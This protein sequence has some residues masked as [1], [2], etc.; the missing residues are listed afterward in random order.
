MANFN[1]ADYETVDQRIR[2]FYADHPTG[3]ITT[4]L[5]SADGAPGSTRWVVKA[6][7]WRG[8]RGGVVVDNEKPIS[9][10]VHSLDLAP[11]GTGYAF[12][13]D[14]TG[15]ANKTSALE[16]C[17]TSAIG[18]ALANIGYSGD[19]RASREEMAKAAAGPVVDEAA[20]AEWVTAMEGAVDLNDLQSAW[21]AAGAKGV[22]RDPRV[23]TAK[24][25]RK[26]ELADG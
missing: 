3:R 10:M 8:D 5:V 25:K 16:N 11:D 18:R 17:E 15:M 12:E 24:D 6:S 9:E 1:L 21:N 2:R 26:K 7:V 4:E 22:T 23:V 14:G 20:V 13:L 19:K